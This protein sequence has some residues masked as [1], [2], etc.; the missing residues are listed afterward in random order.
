MRLR[1]AYKYCEIPKNICDVCKC[2]DIAITYI[3]D[4]CKCRDIAITYIKG[5]VVYSSA[6]RDYIQVAVP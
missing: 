2:W 1:I 5:I 4:V 3:D 6:T